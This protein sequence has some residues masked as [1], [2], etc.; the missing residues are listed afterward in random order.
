[1]SGSKHPLTPIFEALLVADMGP[2]APL[3]P[4]L[5]QPL[6]WP[7]GISY[8]H[9]NT[10]RE[11]LEKRE[12][13][14]LTFKQQRDYQASKYLRD[15]SDLYLTPS[16]PTP[17]TPSASPTASKRSWERKFRDFKESS[18]KWSSFILSQQALPR[19]GDYDKAARLQRELQEHMQKLQD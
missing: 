12:N 5:Q 1:M 10:S 8:N 4:G 7:P 11:R 14:V 18:Q 6:V 13:I 16:C 19:T 17:S 2:C 9:Q 15:H 3:K